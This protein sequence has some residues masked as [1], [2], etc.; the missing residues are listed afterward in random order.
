MHAGIEYYIFIMCITSM[1]T[2]LLDKRK[3]THLDLSI[4]LS[5]MQ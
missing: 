3:D 4:Q 5:E 1:G 2:L